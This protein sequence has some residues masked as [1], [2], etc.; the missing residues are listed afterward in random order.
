MK[1]RVHIVWD[2][3]NIFWA[4]KRLCERIEG[5]SDAFNIHCE[6]LLKL[7]AAGRPIE[8]V[9]FVGDEPSPPESFFDK[10]ANQTGR[11]PEVYRRGVPTGR[12]QAFYKAIYTKLL[13]LWYALIAP[14][15]LVL[16]SGDGSTAHQR[17]SFLSYVKRVYR[18]G[19]NV[20]ILSW[21]DSLDRNLKEWADE[22][23]LVVEL[24]PFY[25]QITYIEGGRLSLPV[26][27]TMR[28]TRPKSL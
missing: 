6:K 22:H 9:Y 23:A 4:G 1:N 27:L 20:E 17:I 12:K 3:S 7:A 2:N 8:Q 15:T 18:F 19:W 11:A 5:S 26:D 25:A 28:P 16:L 21:S 24:D 14:E 13:M 10:I